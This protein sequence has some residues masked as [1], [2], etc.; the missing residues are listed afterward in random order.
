M[1]DRSV[2]RFFCCLYLVLYDITNEIQRSEKGT[3]KMTGYHMCKMKKD[4]NEMRHWK[5]NPLGEERDCV[6]SKE[7]Q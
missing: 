4:L 7:T 5:T 2:L 1:T 6:D 3:G